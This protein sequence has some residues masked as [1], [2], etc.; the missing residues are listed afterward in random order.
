MSPWE[1]TPKQLTQ[2]S[3][4]DQFCRARMSCWARLGSIGAY[5][6]PDRSRLQTFLSGS[7]WPDWNKRITYFSSPRPLCQQT[8]RR[9]IFCRKILEEILLMFK[10]NDLPFID[11]T[12][13]VC[14]WSVLVWVRMRVRLIKE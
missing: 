13:R 6:L 1:L 9:Q 12:K 7:G 8:L 5:G 11:L 2:T 14:G 10:S 4:S 3:L